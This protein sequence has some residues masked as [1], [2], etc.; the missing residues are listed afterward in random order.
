[1]PPPPLSCGGCVPGSE[2]E[3]EFWVT[4]ATL[5]GSADTSTGNPPL[6]AQS[7]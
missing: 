2:A 7:R 6:F 3:L 4:R 1:M 5:A